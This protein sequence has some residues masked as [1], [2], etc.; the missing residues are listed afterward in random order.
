MSL[1]LRGNMGMGV[2][3]RV[4]AGVVSHSGAGLLVVANDHVANDHFPF[5][6]TWNM[7]LSSKILECAQLS[8]T[9]F[10]GRL[11]LSSM[12]HVYTC[13]HRGREI[14]GVFARDPEFQG[15]PW[16]AILIMAREQQVRLAFPC[17]ARSTVRTS[18]ERVFNQTAEKDAMLH[19]SI[20]PRVQ[21][22]S[23]YSVISCGRAIA[24]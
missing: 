22:P 11:V 18:F 14:K 9:Q 12:I 6:P 7:C 1:S 19:V 21:S 5:A 23:P 15:S 20:E 24:I 3:V 2:G 17:R 13:N 4:V 10:K 8:M 16:N